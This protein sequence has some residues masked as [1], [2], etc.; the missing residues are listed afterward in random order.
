MAKEAASVRGAAAR[1]R[2][3][4][5]KAA[6]PPAGVRVVPANDEMRKVL[7][8]PRGARFGE[9]GGAEW[10]NDTFTKRRLNEGAITLEKTDGGE[11]HHGRRKRDDE[12][13]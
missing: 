7:R 3:A 5:I 8:H 9:G 4:K 2:L 10:P 6:R 1:E 13:L 12:V 11:K